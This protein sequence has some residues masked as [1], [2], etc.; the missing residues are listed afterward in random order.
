MFT[1]IHVMIF[2]VVGTHKE[3]LILIPYEETETK[4][5]PIT[6]HATTRQQVRFR[7]NTG[8]FKYG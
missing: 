5:T 7:I 3:K 4:I 2:R 1:V 6:V 8:R